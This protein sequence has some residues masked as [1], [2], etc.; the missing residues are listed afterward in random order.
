MRSFLTLFLLLVS[1]T[2]LS[3]AWVTQAPVVRVH[4]APAVFLTPSQAADLEACA[5]DMLKQ[6][7]SPCVRARVVGWCK[8]VWAAAVQRRRI[9]GDAKE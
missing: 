5:Y 4:R 9:E 1:W 6:P 3:A 8:K 7:P 2:A